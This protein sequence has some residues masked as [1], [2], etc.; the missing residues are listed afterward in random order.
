MPGQGLAPHSP[1]KTVWTV[2]K[3]EPMGTTIIA[4]V[5]AS[6][7][8]ITSLRARGQMSAASD[9]QTLGRDGPSAGRRPGSL[10]AA[11]QA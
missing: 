10:T 6:S 5:K 1:L 2:A 8:K 3:Y 4:K 9:T 11:P 7:F